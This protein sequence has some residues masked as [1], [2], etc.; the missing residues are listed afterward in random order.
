MDNL[1]KIE[2]FTL[3]DGRIAE[4]HTTT[5]EAG[6]TVVE[7]FVEEKKPLKLEKRVTEKRKDILAEKI[8]ETIKDG[9]VV[10]RQVHSIDSG[11]KMELREHLGVADDV[12][13]LNYVSKKE[14]ADAIV[15][16]VKAAMDNNPIAAQSIIVTKAQQTQQAIEGRVTA[17]ADVSKKN[18]IT[19]GI[20]IA[21]E[22]AAVVT[23]LIV[24]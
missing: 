13:A 3:E 19:C 23:A 14:L 18:Y 8:V 1:P 20:I 2:R 17:Q 16:G 15:A 4:R 11:V 7:V 10:E 12:N 22:I 24:F 6:E 9:E 5:N 21:L